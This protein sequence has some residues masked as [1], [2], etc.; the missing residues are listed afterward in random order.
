MR[1]AQAWA[2]DTKEL[3]RATLEAFL[4]LLAVQ[5]QGAASTHHHA[6]G[7]VRFLHRD[8]R[9]KPLDRPSAGRR[10]KPPTRWPTVLTKAEALQA[11]A[12]LSG[13][14]QCMRQWLDGRGRRWRERLRL[15]VPELDGTQD[16]IRAREGPGLKARG[17]KRPDPLSVPLRDQQGRVT[18]GQ[19]QEGA[20]GCGSDHLP[21]A[22]ERYS[23]L[24]SDI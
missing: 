8:G 4:T 1:R 20:K 13:T 12:C 6:R 11:M 19:A 3:T 9:N 15:R 17:T 24:H 5:R 23:G 16:R 7:A 14:E 21:C 10:A 22:L 2:V 18:Q